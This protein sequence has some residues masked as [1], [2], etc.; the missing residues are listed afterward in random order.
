MGE[1]MTADFALSVHNMALTQRKP[2]DVIDLRA[3]YTNVA[4][5]ERRRR[6]RVRPF[7]E[8]VGDANHDAWPRVLRQPGGRTRR[9]RR[10][11]PRAQPAWPATP[12]EGWYDPG[13]HHSSLDFLLSLSIERG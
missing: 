5:G 1:P 11:K 3:R 8:T 10:S 7:A 13:R 12:I 2:Q 4:L 6:T 9:A